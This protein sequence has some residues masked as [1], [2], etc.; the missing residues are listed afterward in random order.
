MKKNKDK[1]HAFMKRRN[2]NNTSNMK[3]KN[4]RGM[5]R[6]NRYLSTNHP[7]KNYN[8]IKTMN[9]MRGIRGMRGMKYI[10]KEASTSSRIENEL[11]RKYYLIKPI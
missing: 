1:R 9:G 11:N 3:Q 8:T 4:H 7:T 6:D 10:Q 5:R 2:Q